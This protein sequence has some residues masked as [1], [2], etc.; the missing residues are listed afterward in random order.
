MLLLFYKFLHIWWQPPTVFSYYSTRMMLAAIT[1]FLLTLFLGPYF[2]RKLYSLKIG[3]PLRYGQECPLLAELHSKK[4]DT[5][6][7]GGVLILA[8]MLVSLVLWMDWSSIF[9]WLLLLTTL[10][11]GF[12]GGIDDFLKMK[13]KNKKGLPAFAKFLAQVVLALAIGWYLISPSLQNTGEKIGLK[14]PTAKEQIS[15]QKNLQVR[16]LNTKQYISRIYMPFIKKPLFSLGTFALLLFIA[17]VITGTSNAVNLTDGLDGLAVGCVTMVA[18]VLGLVAFLS[19]NIE[20]ARYLNILHIEN[21]GEIGVYLCSLIGGSLGFLWYNG[22][23]AQIFMGDTGSLTLGGVLGISAVL[24]SR[25]LLLALAAGVMVAEVLS[26]ILQVLSYRLRGEKR[27]FLCSPLH[28]H[29]EYK[30]WAEMKVVLRFW[31]IGLLLALIC[32][33]SMKFQ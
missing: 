5:P 15:W 10:F 7:M 22:Y 19:S 11:L 8:A 31:L 9:T 1:S 3:Q 26:V 32:V 23:P 12:L 29:F 33:A 6:T 2:I 27:I 21:S 24:L 18:G 25:E 17:F 30:G 4:K 28:H 14:A 16:T 13:Y 20:I